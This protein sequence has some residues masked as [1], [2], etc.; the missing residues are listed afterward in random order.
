ML[1]RYTQVPPPAVA[2]TLERNRKALRRR[3]AALRGLPDADFADAYTAMVAAVEAGFRHEE[4]LLEL[5]DGAC[6]PA[7]LADHATLL[8]ALHRA[9][10]RVENGDL[11][12]GREL[13]DALDAVL[14]LPRRPLVHPPYL[15]PARHHH[16]APAGPPAR[17]A[18]R[19]AND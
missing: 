9:M 2:A 7:C 18:G 10:P 6:P 1:F 14:M 4:V 15:V 17:S 3:V 12:L 16:T 11:R 19:P 8:C 5:L 13:V